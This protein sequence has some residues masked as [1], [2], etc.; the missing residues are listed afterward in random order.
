M[1]YLGLNNQSKNAAISSYCA[2]HSIRKVFLVTPEK[3][4]FN[5]GFDNIETIEWAEVILYKFFYRLLQEINDETLIVINECL[6]TQNRY[7]LTYNCIRHF[8]N[9]TIH[10]MVFQYL[11]IINDAQDFMTLFDFDTRSRW[12]RE[13]LRPELL[14]ESEIV[15]EKVPVAFQSVDIQVGER[16]RHLYRTEKERLIANIGL[17]DPHTIPRNLY[18]IS[19]KE[20]LRHVEPGKYYLGRNNR[21]KMERLQTYR[22]HSYPHHYTVFEFCHNFIDFSDV[23]TLSGQQ[24]FDV[25]VADLKVDEWYFNRYQDWLKKLRDAYSILQR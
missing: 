22:E 10:R 12:K 25:F 7:D 20:K 14:S 13:G 4:K 2:S 1:I 16:V 21:L 6:R 3:F 23:L 24:R 11:P 8:L 18:L 15:T 9:Q 5:C 19:G 17:K